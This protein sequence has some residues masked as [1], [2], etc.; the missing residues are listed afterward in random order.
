MRKLPIKYALDDGVSK[1]VPLDAQVAGPVSFMITPSS[2][3]SVAIEATNY[4]LSDVNADT[5]SWVAL[6]NSPYTAAALS[7]TAGNVTALRC[8]ST[9]GAAVL[10]VS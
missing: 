1:V 5:A 6:P 8:V 9:G 4:P 7:G 2:G 10:V 3:A